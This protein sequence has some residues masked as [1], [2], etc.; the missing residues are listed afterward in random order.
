MEAPFDEDEDLYAPIPVSN[1]VS[2][3]IRTERHHKGINNIVDNLYGPP[4]HFQ[5]EG[6]FNSS[7]EGRVNYDPDE[8]PEALNCPE[9]MDTEVTTTKPIEYSPLRPHGVTTD[10]NI[11]FSA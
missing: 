2:R 10:K 5:G 3:Q 9:P 6:E 7:N 8:F 1:K 4:A 11:T